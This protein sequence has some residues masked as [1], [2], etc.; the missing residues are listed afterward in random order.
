VVTP[1]NARF[2]ARIIMSRSQCHLH[3][4]A[5]L[6]LQSKSITAGRINQVETAYNYSS[7]FKN[8]QIPTFILQLPLSHYPTNFPDIQTYTY[9]HMQKERLHCR[10]NFTP[11]KIPKDDYIADKNSSGICQN[12]L[13]WT[14]E[15]LIIIPILDLFLIAIPFEKN[16]FDRNSVR[17]KKY[18]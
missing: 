11:K 17:T 16:M 7:S 2:R 3:P 10:P 15:N 14:R 18:I 6:N 1:H 13:H 8:T 9:I 5:W 4:H 12:R